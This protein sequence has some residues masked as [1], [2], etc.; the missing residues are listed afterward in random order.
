M[1][2][3]A[4][5]IKETLR[6]WPPASSARLTK[7]GM[8]LT[9]QTSTGESHCLDGVL[10]YLCGSI[11]Q[12]DPKVYGDTANDFVPERWLN[13]ND[14][15][16]PP[17]AWRPFERGPRACIGLELASLEARL[18]VALVSQ[19]YDFCKIGIGE[20]VRDEAGQPVLGA[21][22]QHLTEPEIYTVSYPLP[23]ISNN[24]I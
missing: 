14:E 6:L 16:I 8:G 3:T 10:V 23:V 22:G 7:P 9:V 1:E 4:A 11:I 20:S 5:V 17:S 15:N 2:Y 13:G 18:V 21:C 24:N 12:R 19:R